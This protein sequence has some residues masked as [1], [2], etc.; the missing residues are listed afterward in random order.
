MDPL[1]SHHNK[2]DKLVFISYILA[3]IFVITKSRHEETVATEMKQL[4]GA[5]CTCR[6]KKL[7]RKSDWKIRLRGAVS[8]D[9]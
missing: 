2:C 7:I 4:R 6:V 1:T 3:F 9:R 8:R 5:A